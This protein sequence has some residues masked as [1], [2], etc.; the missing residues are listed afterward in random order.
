MDEDIPI[1]CT[2]CDGSMLVLERTA[3][4][5]LEEKEDT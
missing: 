3:A 4:N 1:T 5:Y 2:L